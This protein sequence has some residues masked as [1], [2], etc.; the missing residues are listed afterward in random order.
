MPS[1]Y[2]QSGFNLVRRIVFVVLLVGSLVLV[3]LY[4]REGEAGRLHSIQNSVMSVTMP[5]AGLGRPLGIATNAVSTAVDDARASQETLS[6]LR[7]QNEQLRRMLS[8]TEEYRQEVERLRGLL[9]IK[10]VSGVNGPVA[11][12]IGRSTNAWDQSITIDLGKEDGIE[13]GMTVMGATG[14]I[15]QVARVTDHMSTVRLLTDP[16]SGAA[17]K[18]QSSRANAIVRGSLTGLLYLEDIEDDQIPSVGDVVITSGLGGSYSS[19]LIVGAI[20]VVNKTAGNATGTIIVNPNDTASDLEVVIVVTDD[21]NVKA[22]TV[23]T[24][25]NTPGSE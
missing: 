24:V 20:S 16:N 11:N 15:G 25:A 5:I 13:P 9:D 12:V 8:D 7:E 23:T 1:D 18:I 22:A 21:K 3:T 17:V 14:V 4:S 10:R 2:R 19:G 6:A